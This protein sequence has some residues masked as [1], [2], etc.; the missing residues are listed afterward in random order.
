MATVIY[1]EAASPAL[2]RFRSFLRLL[3]AFHPRVG[4]D[5]YSQFIGAPSGLV[6]GWNAV[7]QAAGAEVP[8]R[9][10]YIPLPG[11]KGGGLN[12]EELPDVP[13]DQIHVIRED[14]LPRFE[15]SLAWHQ[16]M[17]LSEM[18]SE[19]QP[20]GVKADWVRERMDRLHALAA[21]PL[22]GKD[23]DVD[24]R[25]DQILADIRNRVNSSIGSPSM[26]AEQV[27]R[28]I[29]DYLDFSLT[30]QQASNVLGVILAYYAVKF[31]SP[32]DRTGGVDPVK[33]QIDYLIELAST[34]TRD[35]QLYDLGSYSQLTYLGILLA[36][37]AVLMAKSLA[38]RSQ[39]ENLIHWFKRRALYADEWSAHNLIPSLMHPMSLAP[40]G[41]VELLQAH[42]VGVINPIGLYSGA[43]EVGD[44]PFDLE[45]MEVI[46]PRL[47]SYSSSCNRLE[48]NFG[49]YGRVIS[50]ALEEHLSYFLLTMRFGQL[51]RKKD[52]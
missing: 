1:D 15:G 49:A 29:N 25:I 24:H 47:Q 51:M 18:V 6:P 28:V 39:G 26:F 32:R 14:D 27:I 12:T 3:M 36:D 40:F 50:P 30:K 33:K 46:W 44:G 16:I 35:R 21:T 38:T 42:K 9:Y 23:E 31:P 11:S 52:S 4:A 20:Q 2:Y 10:I 37:A 17:Q 43:G 34:I 22:R 7:H 45:V 8:V 41:M 19:Q 48:E 13:E 5:L